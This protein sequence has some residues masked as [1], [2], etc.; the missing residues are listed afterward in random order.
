LRAAP[1]LLGTGRQCADQRLNI[2]SGFSVLFC[3]L[4][5][6]ATSGVCLIR[7]ACLKRP[8][9]EL[10]S[11]LNWGGWYGF[12]YRRVLALPYLLKTW[13]MYTYFK[14]AACERE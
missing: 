2:S 8:R 7:S 13:S 14:R 9:G 6:A 12:I 5:F 10:S 4:Y 3:R 11:E 1:A